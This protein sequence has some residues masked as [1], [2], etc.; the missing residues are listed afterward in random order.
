MPATRTREDWTALIRHVEASGESPRS[1]CAKRDIRLKTFEWWRWQL[2][3]QGVL[4]ASRS[5]GAM[6]PT[7]VRLLPVTVAGAEFATPMPTPIE[8]S[9]QDV[10]LRFVDDA[11]GTDLPP[12]GPVATGGG[13]TAEAATRGGTLSSAAWT[14]AGLTLAATI[15]L[16]GAAMRR[17]RSHQ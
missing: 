9:I 4:P 13:A 17:P 11:V 15:A 1:F 8:L 10:T 7:P 14:V 5:P 6:A 16:A 2:R 3:R 12:A